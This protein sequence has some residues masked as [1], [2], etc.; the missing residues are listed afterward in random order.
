MFASKGLNLN[1]EEPQP[2]SR[3]TARIKSLTVGD[4]LSRVGVFV[5]IDK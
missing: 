2:T 3:L 4:F 1:K 5:G